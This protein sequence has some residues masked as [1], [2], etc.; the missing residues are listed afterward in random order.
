MNVLEIKDL[1]VRYTIGRKEIHAVENLSISVKE[2]RFLGVVGESG[3]GKST[4][5]HTVMRLLPKN[6]Y[7]LKGQIKLLG[8]EILSMSEDDIRQLRWKEFS[9]VFQRSMNALSPVHKIGVQMSE[10]LMIHNPQMS[11]EQIKNR[12]ESL[13]GAVNLPVRVLDCYPHQL[14]GGMMQRV[15]IALALVNSPKFV[16]LDEATTAL[17]VVT[18]GQIIEELKNLIGKF[19]LTG[20]V[21]SHDLG[22]VAELCDD[23]A[24]MYAGRLMEYGSK[25]GIIHSPFHPY[26]KALV[27][28]LPDFGKKGGR[29]YSIPGNLPDLSQE[30]NYCVFASRC[31]IAS[32]ECFEEVPFHVEVQGHRVACLKVGKDHAHI[33]GK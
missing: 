7:V 15:M 32:K 22:V 10:A 23:I 31:E 27:G 26:T 20:M 17:D 33:A 18:Q 2:G 1:T 6:A 14:S 3:S 8:H 9:M 30:M 16:I 12:L 29:L 5:A 4:L 25:D 28:S 11:E 24:V 21:I 13:L 19:S